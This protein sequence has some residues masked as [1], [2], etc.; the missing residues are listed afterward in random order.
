MNEKS[1]R[2]NIYLRM[3]DFVT[4]TAHSL[5]KLEYENFE[6]RY[7]WDG[8]Q[9]NELQMDEIKKGLDGGLS[10]DTVSVYA[11]P[12]IPACVMNYMR[13][14]IVI[15]EMDYTSVFNEIFRRQPLGCEIGTTTL[16][17]EDIDRVICLCSMAHMGMA[18]SEFLPRRY[19]AD[20]LKARMELEAEGGIE[21]LKQEGLEQIKSAEIKEVA[22]NSATHLNA[23][24]DS[25]H[26]PMEGFNAGRNKIFSGVNSLG[27]S[28]LNQQVGI[29]SKTIDEDAEYG[30]MSP[31]FETG[32]S[33]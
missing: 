14:S 7:D 23:N 3:N 24:N 4:T 29:P 15:G 10:Y 17:P 9:F 18:L 31:A 27:R 25:R 19:T 5:Y 13:T 16:H 21:K 12:Y 28:R 8:M 6:R 32:H 33:R 11:K 1:F 26:T 22:S 30:D 2:A 20:E